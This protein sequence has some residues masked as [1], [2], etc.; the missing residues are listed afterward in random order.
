MQDSAVAPHD[1][2]ERANRR[3]KHDR[4]TGLAILGAAFLSA[5]AISWVAKRAAEPE[6]APPPEPPDTSGL[7]SF[8]S[9]F[10]PMS[11]LER[12]RSLSVRTRLQGITLEGVR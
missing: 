1:S 3:V 7:L 2:G 9:A 5:L 4:A 11:A 8:P 6:P 10:D 12:A